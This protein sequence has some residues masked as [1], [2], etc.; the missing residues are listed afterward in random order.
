MPRGFRIYGFILNPY[1]GKPFNTKA[2][3]SILVEFYKISLSAESLVP[4]VDN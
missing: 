3:Y 2:T 1:K 4:N